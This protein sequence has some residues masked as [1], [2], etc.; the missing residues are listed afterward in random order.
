MSLLILEFR[1]KAVATGL[2]S[3]FFEDEG[4]PVQP[5]SNDQSAVAT[6][7][8]GNQKQTSDSRS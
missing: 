5:L 6:R 7:N 4:F 1:F 3:V 2:K 8:F